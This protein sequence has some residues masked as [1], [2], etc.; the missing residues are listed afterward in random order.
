MLKGPGD[1]RPICLQCGYEEVTIVSEPLKRSKVSEPKKRGRPRKM[2]L[3]EPIQ[4]REPLPQQDFVCKDC[5][6]V[7]GKQWV[8]NRHMATHQEVLV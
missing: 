1:D 7:F 5:K 3:G 6:R 4:L 2:Q 8:L